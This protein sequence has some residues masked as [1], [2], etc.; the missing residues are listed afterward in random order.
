[1]RLPRRQARAPRTSPSG[2][3]T[4]R[5]VPAG[6]GT[7]SRSSTIRATNLASGSKSRPPESDTASAGIPSMIP[8]SAAA[9]VPE[10]VM[11]SPR[12]APWLI[13]DTISS[14][15]AS[16]RPSEAKR[17]QSTGVPSV[18]KP[19][20]PSPNSTSSTQ[21][22]SWRVTARPVAL[23]FESGAMT[24]SSTSGSSRS[25]LRIT[26]RPVAVM[27]SSFVSRTRIWWLSRVCDAL[28]VEPVGWRRRPRLAARA[29]LEQLPEALR[30][31]ALE[32]GADQH[33]HHV[34]HERVRLDPE[35]EHVARL[36]EPL[37]PQHVALE[38]HVVRLRGS[39]GGEV[40]RAHERGGAGA[41]GVA[42]ERPRP[43]ERAV[44]LEGARGA[45]RVYAVAI[46]ARAR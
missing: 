2:P 7:S 17:T 10:Y 35:G 13:P 24:S 20:V 1:M 40:V 33:A 11:S 5:S 19:V 46:R 4:L 34:A 3:F 29:P 6:I 28:E 22:G 30:P 16:I 36:L 14:G 18:A 41:K 15:G 38:A 45:P 9:T 21:I 12:F 26:L 31:R 25:A 39:E 32:H 8:S 42:V 27:P 44:P 37:G 23:R 43:P